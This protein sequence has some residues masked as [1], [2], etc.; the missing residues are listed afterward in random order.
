MGEYS[1][2]SEHK[3]EFLEQLT[4]E[5]LEFLLCLSSDSAEMEELID[6]IAKVIVSREEEHPTGRLPN[7]DDAWDE[8]QRVYNTQEKREQIRPETNPSLADLDGSP[9][10]ARPIRNHA[11]FRHLWHAA[12][13]AVLAIV[14]TLGFMI[15]AQASGVNVF[16]ALAQ[17][18][19]DIFHYV[20]TPADNDPIKQLLR[21]QGIP[22]E[23]A[24]TWVPE[25]FEFQ[26]VDSS[27]SDEGK[28][29]T[30]GYVGMD[31]TLGIEIGK[32][33]SPV[34]L[35]NWDY[36]KDSDDAKPFVSLGRKFYILSNL[37]CTTATW[38]DGQSLIVN[39]WG[40]VSSEEMID[41]ISSIGG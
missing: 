20:A 15:G 2:S 30:I 14:L 10:E 37:E 31:G 8:F 41:I 19:D 24:P 1:G 11:T 26:E 21:D 39:I 33:N 29:V 17:W 35:V 18:T 4:M 16:G 7:T 27:S 5:D 13:V 34:H 23:L 22:E 3:F 28:S 12:L 9:M 38:S 6:A 25:R 40:D 32:Y 36:Q